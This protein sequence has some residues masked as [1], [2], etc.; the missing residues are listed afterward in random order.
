MILFQIIFYVKQIG[1]NP[2]YIAFHNSQ[3]ISRMWI[4]YNFFTK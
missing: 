1:F 2:T 4:V 3:T